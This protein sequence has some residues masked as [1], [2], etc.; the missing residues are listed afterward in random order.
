[1]W[2]GDEN[3]S[4]GKFYKG[5]NSVGFPCTGGVLS[6]INISGVSVNETTL[7]VDLNICNKSIISNIRSINLTTNQF[8]DDNII[9]F[10][11]DCGLWCWL[12]IGRP[13]HR[14]SN[15]FSVRGC[16]IINWPDSHRARETFAFV[17]H[18]FI[19]LKYKIYNLHYVYQ[20]E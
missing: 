15:L 18:K 17:L 16:V 7:L 13:L 20:Q 6:I 19:L 3:L 12:F 1:M 4:L 8:A 11:L 5:C 9:G 2:D 14:V 10:E